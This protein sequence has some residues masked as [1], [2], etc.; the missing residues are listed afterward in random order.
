[1]HSHVHK[2]TS[3]DPFIGFGL[4]LVS[5]VTNVSRKFALSVSTPSAD[6]SG[7]SCHKLMQLPADVCAKSQELEGSGTGDAR[8]GAQN[9][10]IQMPQK[11][12]GVE[13]VSGAK[14]QELEG[15]R[16]RNRKGQER[17]SGSQH[18]NAAEE[19]RR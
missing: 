7:R 11:S 1:M 13:A 8:N 2:M 5:R 3:C 14:S 18:P 6:N 12:G 19:R 10:S 4:D 15:L 17:D 9:S 16:L